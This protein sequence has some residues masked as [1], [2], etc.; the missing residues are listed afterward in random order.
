[1]WQKWGRTGSPAPRRI[2][3]EAWGECGGLGGRAP[4][5]PSPLIT[6]GEVTWV[7]SHAPYMPEENEVHWA[8]TGWV[9]G[10]MC[11]C[12]SMQTRRAVNENAHASDP[13]SHRVRPWMLTLSN[14]VKPYIICMDKRLKYLPAHV[15]HILV[16]DF[17]SAQEHSI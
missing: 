9:G 16:C 17:G 14:C 5:R 15:I 2:S 4:I 6:G 3:P 13:T 11:H 7:A 10:K 1:M 12:L 8:I